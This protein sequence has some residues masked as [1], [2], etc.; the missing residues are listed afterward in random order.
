M[1]KNRIQNLKF[2]IKSD[3]YFGTLATILDLLRLDTLEKK[4]IFDKNKVLKRIVK[5]LV[6]LQDNY[7]ITK[8]IK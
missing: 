4:F 7:K 1:K 3:D 2:H 6:Y 5:D 8:K